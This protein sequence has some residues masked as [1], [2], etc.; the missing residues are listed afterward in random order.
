MRRPAWAGGLFLGLVLLGAPV[1][2]VVTTP[3]PLA[4]ILSDKQYRYIVVAKVDA[5]DADKLTMVLKVDEHL[6][7]K[8]PFARLPVNLKSREKTAKEQIPVL[9]KR[10]GE[11]LPVVLFI[12]DLEDGDYTGF[13]YTNGTWFM[14]I[15]KTPDGADA[16]RWLFTELEPYLRRTFKGTTAEMRQVVIDGLSG[17]KAPPPWDEKEK[18]GVGPEVKPENEEEASGSLSPQR[19]ARAQRSPLLGAA[20]S[21]TLVAAPTFAVIPSVII[22]GPLAILAMIFPT[23]FGGWRR[24][25]ALISGLCTVSTVIFVYWMWGHHFATSAWG[26]D[27]AQWL[28]ITVIVVLSAAWAWQ[29]HVRRLRTGEAP[30]APSRAEFIVLGVLALIA[31]GTLAICWKLGVRLTSPSWLILAPM[32]I[33]AVFGMAFVAL[34]R[35][36][37]RAETPWEELDLW[38]PAAPSGNGHAAL[39]HASSSGGTAVAVAEKPRVATTSPTAPPRAPALATE[40]VMLTV[41]A[42]ACTALAGALEPRGVGPGTAVSE[43]FLVHGGDK[44]WMYRP[45]VSGL[46]AS[47]PLVVG[48]RVYVGATLGSQGVVFCLDRATGKVIWDTRKSL[49]WMKHISISSP[50]L[51]DG[52]L[53]IGEGFHQ[54]SNCKVYCIN[55]E[56]GKEVWNY[57][58]GSHTESSPF[59]AEG[60]VY[61]GAGDDGLYCLDAKTGDELWHYNGLHIDANPLVH[62]KRLYVGAGEGDVQTET[63]ILCLDAESGKEVWKRRLDL[64]AWG[65]PVLAGDRVFFGIGN[66]RFDASDLGKPAG[67]V[68]CVN[69]SDGETDWRFDTRDGVLCRPSVDRCRVWC[70][71]RDGNLYCLDRRTG[72]LHWKRD[73]GSPVVTA[74]AVVRC[75]PGGLA[76][77]VYA[78]GSEGQT[79]CLEPNTGA[80]YWQHDLTDGGRLAVTLWSSPSLTVAGHDQARETRQ[81]IFGATLGSV[82]APSPAVFCFKDRLDGSA[83]DV[84]VE[85]R[86]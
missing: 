18:P 39:E 69:A 25:L 40:V 44:V 10:L 37:P 15:G 26:G 61:I 56:T 46:I 34:A 32:G 58:T 42:V 67:A 65:S 72:K 43:L 79:F 21:Q 83:D 70:G 17:K 86:P 82:D 55:A 13:V 53:Y 84:I 81:L 73:L 9:T 63:A 71:C 36:Q 28:M 5:F 85:S 31:F 52:K 35:R 29:R 23:W 48:D 4:S 16:P 38:T 66:G 3:T 49:K 8:A 6:K 57:P 62:E 68:L 54:D 30:A 2:A 27:L 11:K 7:G 20:G 77:A 19:Q 60:K 45:D 75:A 33:A 12:K 22:G 51:V 76:N 80:V 78:L 59:V 14:M 50:V 47:S 24:W 64:P 41:M 1:R 74:A